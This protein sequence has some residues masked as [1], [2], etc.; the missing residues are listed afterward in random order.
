LFE[1]VILIGVKVGIVGVV[2]IVGRGGGERLVTA[3]VVAMNVVDVV[4]EVVAMTDNKRCY[5]HRIEHSDVSVDGEEKSRGREREHERR[6][7]RQAF[8]SIGC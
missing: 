1:E 2:I 3:I 4:V 7:F 6:D 5:T 8:S